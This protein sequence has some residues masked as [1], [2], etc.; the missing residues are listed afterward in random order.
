[1][2]PIS[3][4]FACFVTLFISLILPVLVLIVYG[5]KNRGKGVCSAWLLGAVGFFV[6]QILI[7]LPLLNL[8]SASAGFVSFAQTHPFSYVLALAFTAGLFELAGRYAVARCMKRDLTFQRALAAG[9]GHGGI[10]AMLIVGTTYI[11]NLIY[12]FMIQ[13]GAFD[14]LVAQ[15]AAAGGDVSQ[16]QA[17]RDS[18]V[19]VSASLFLMGGLE[20][21]L[22]MVC[23]A[24]MSVIVCWGVHTGRVRTGLLICLGIHTLIDAMAGLQFLVGKGLSQGAAYGIIYGVLALVALGSLV[25]LKKLRGCWEKEETL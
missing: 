8:L 18:L 24:A 12:L 20:R 14:A 13:S 23:Q 10:E 21:I 2:I 17:V 22:T 1:M 19:N 25:I 5:V 16:L 15:T 3:T 6:P 11:N 9:L 4:F 7:W